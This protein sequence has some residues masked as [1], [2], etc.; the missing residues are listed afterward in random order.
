MVIAHKFGY[1]DIDAGK[2]L[3]LEGVVDVC[4]L[5]WGQMIL[6]CVGILVVVL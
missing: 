5:G 2:L 1:I 3:L 4:F 6:L